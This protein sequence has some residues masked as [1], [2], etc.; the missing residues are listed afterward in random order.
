MKR[1]APETIQQHD[2]R[3]LRAKRLSAIAIVLDAESIQRKK[4]G[5]FRLSAHDVADRSNI[6]VLI[7]QQLGRE[8]FASLRI[9]GRVVGY[10]RGEFYVADD[11]ASDRSRNPA[12]YRRA[13]G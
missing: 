7:V 9:P 6:P 8:H 3:A 10:D 2:A 13:D 1:R 4:S 12:R 5:E 11:E